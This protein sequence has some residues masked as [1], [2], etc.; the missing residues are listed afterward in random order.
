MVFYNTKN[1]DLNAMRRSLN[2]LNKT[3]KKAKKSRKRKRKGRTK[4]HPIMLVIC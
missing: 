1:V 2:S 3:V 4:V